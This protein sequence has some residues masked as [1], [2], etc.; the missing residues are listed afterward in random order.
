MAL[1]FFTKFYGWMWLMSCGGR[2]ICK[3]PVGESGTFWQQM[4]M[5]HAKQCDNSGIILWNSGKDGKEKRM[6]EHQ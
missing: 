2:N 1:I 5:M 4:I 3:F 6:I